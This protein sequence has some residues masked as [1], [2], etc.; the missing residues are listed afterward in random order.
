M[1]V[2]AIG[3]SDVDIRKEFFRGIIVSG[4]GSLFNG[5]VERLN[6]ELVETVPQ[7]MKKEVKLI[8]PAM[9]AERK[10]STFIGGSILGS[11]GTFQKMW[12]SKSE[13]AEHGKGLVERKCP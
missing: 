3:K 2:N 13:Y 10:Y 7:Q 9:S 12:M 11:L 4:G 8:A 5:F 1:I 6:T